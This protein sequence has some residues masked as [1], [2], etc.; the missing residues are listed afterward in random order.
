MNSCVRLA[1]AYCG[2]PS[3]VEGYLRNTRRAGLSNNAVL[4]SL[5]LRI[6]VVLAPAFN[7]ARALNRLEVRVPIVLLANYR[8]ESETRPTKRR[9][10]SA[11]TFGMASQWS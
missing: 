4:D 7:L 3:D 1:C 2:K 11:T 6:T 9:R 8:D 5:R 10:N